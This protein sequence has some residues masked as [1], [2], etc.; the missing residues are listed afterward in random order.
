MKD[1]KLISNP[2]HKKIHCGDEIVIIVPDIIVSINKDVD[3]REEI[4]K[5]K[6]EFN[7]LNLRLEV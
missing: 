5:K 2:A 4:I 6:K 3:G 7:L 1:N